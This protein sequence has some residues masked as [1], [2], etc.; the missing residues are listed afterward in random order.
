MYI[1]ENNGT[2]GRKRRE[3]EF[4]KLTDDEVTS[5]QTIVRDSFDGYTET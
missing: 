4:A 1:R 5:I 2:F 3:N